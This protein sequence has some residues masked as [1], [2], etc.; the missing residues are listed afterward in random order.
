MHKKK[1]TTNWWYFNFAAKADI[2][3]A[4]A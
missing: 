4:K 1:R 2:Y 3:F